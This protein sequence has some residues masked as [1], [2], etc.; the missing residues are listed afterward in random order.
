MSKDSGLRKRTKIVCTIGPASSN[1]ATLKEMIKA[2]MNVARLNFSHGSAESNLELLEKVRRASK[3]VGI[4]VA[5]LQDLQGPKIRIGT[6]PGEGLE[7]IEGKIVSVLAGAETAD[8]GIIPIPYERLAHDLRRGDRILLA[9]GTRELEVVEKRGKL[10]KARVLLGGR[11]ISRKGLNVPTVSLSVES[12]TEKDDADLAFGLKQNIDFVALSFVRN[13][14]DVLDL[15]KK[16]TKGLPAGME[17]PQVVVKIEKHEAIE[18]FDEILEATDGVMIARGDLGLETPVSRVPVHQKE[19]IAKCVVAGKPV[20][21]ATEMMAS[22]EYNPRPTRAEVSDVANAVIDHTDATMLSGE[23][24]MGRYPTRAVGT[25]A[26]VI[27]VTEESPLDNLMPHEHATG[28]P[29]PVAVASAAVQVA[30]N[31]G[32]VAILATT[33]S[34]FSARAVASFR[35]EIPLFAATNSLRTRNQLLLSWGVTPFVIDA[36]ED[37]AKMTELALKEL[38]KSYGMKKGSKV[39]VMSGLAK[40]KGHYDTIVRVIEL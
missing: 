9:D 4:P 14:K 8:H 10:I 15:K 34:G 29:V 21:T 5:I 26:E 20:I 28:A 23:S 39:V 11:I 40:Q 30:R 7:L 33:A 16:I 35:P 22:M 24:A 6:I 37:P 2:G 27:Q 36:Y 12:M 13:A 18:N 38:Q 17:P 32:A 25:M 1:E 19:L 3:A 31:I